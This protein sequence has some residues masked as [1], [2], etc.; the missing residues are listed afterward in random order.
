[1]NDY[2]F[3]KLQINKQIS[4]LPGTNGPTSNGS[5]NRVKSNV[6]RF[7][8]SL[9]PGFT[10]YKSLLYKKLLKIEDYVTKIQNGAINNNIQN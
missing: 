9:D 7:C 2:F 5:R 3:T 6:C 1:M 4:S 8:Y 10:N